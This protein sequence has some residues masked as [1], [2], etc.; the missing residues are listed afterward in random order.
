MI[1][2]SAGIAYEQNRPTGVTSAL[3]AQFRFLAKT[4][5]KMP[6][7]KHFSDIS[8]CKSQY[9]TLNAKYFFDRPKDLASALMAQFGFLVKRY[10]KNAFYKNCFQTKVVTNQNLQP[11]YYITFFD[12]LCHFGDIAVYLT[13]REHIVPSYGT[14][15]C[16]FAR[17]SIALVQ[18]TDIEILRF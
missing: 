2:I 12:I 15:F 18:K 11:L 9:A 8:C 14:D 6:Y 10:L 13:H 17:E 7:T 1:K 16:F 3:M 5:L 4:A